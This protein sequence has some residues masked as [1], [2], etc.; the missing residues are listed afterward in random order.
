MNGLTTPGVVGL[1]SKWDKSESFSDQISVHFCS[2]VANLTHFGYKSDIPGRVKDSD[3]DTLITTPSR[4]IAT[5][6]IVS[7]SVD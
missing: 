7:P 4:M 6:C 3:N 1:A 2:F 5:P